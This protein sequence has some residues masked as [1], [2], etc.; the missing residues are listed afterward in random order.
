M[1]PRTIAIVQASFAQVAPVADQAAQMFYARL[2]EA[3]PA[4]RALFRGDL[5]TQGSRL[6]AM[7]GAAVQMLGRPR[8]LEPTLRALGAR[9][10]AYGVRDTHYAAV[11][12]ALL[13]TLA[14]GLGSEFT[15][16]LRAAWAAFYA[17]VAAAMQDGASHAGRAQA[18]TV[19]LG[20]AGG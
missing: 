17:K 12:E 16:E 5:R 3:Q 4:L 10:A 14:E 8:E 2:F 11:G 20:A 18:P 15:P 1:D 6:M 13:D 7:I 19:R 9:H